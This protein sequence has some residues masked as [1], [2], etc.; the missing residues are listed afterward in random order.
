VN[1]P[2][3]I[4]LV[5]VVMLSLAAL[6]GVGG[7]AVGLFVLRVEYTALAQRVRDLEND[8]RRDPE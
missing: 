5:G 6:L 8:A 3:E 4:Q 2:P 1:L 7:A